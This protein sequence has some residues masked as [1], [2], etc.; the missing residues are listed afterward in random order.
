ME[1]QMDESL[2]EDKSVDT[3]SQSD[4]PENQNNESADQQVDSVSSDTQEPD[5]SEDNQPDRTTD[6]DNSDDDGLAKFAKS[7]GYNPDELTDGER[8]AL[9]LAH[10][11]Q[12]AYR[13]SQQ[14]KS[15]DLTKAVTDVN[16]V[17]EEELEDADPSDARIER[18][19][20]E[21]RVQRQKIRANE[22]YESNPEAREYDK[23]M[24]QVILDEVSKYTNPEEGKA[25]GRFLA[26]DLDR[27]LVLAKAKR[28]DDSPEQARRDGAREEREKLRKKQE[29]AAD[30]AHA[31]QSSRSSKK[32][33]R[34]DIA[35]MSDEQYK[36]LRDSG[37]L[38]EAINRGDLY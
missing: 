13:Q 33:T 21:L 37:E 26:Q 32:I 1:N 12:K 30:S 3:G 15:E 17:S 6:D 22:F 27:L 19:E 36:E 34:Q 20:A 25:A 14:K 9:K 35:N 8:K 38:Q 23:E 7:Q 24:G 10:D 18:V 29:G 2:T 4:L 5:Q 28:G 31:S 11:N 16:S